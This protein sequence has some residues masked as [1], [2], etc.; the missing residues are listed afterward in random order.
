MDDHGKDRQ[1]RRMS[2][3]HHSPRNITR[4]NHASSGPVS[5]PSFSPIQRKRRRPE[6]DIFQ[7]E[8]RKI[9]PPTFSG[10]HMKGEDE[11]AWLLEMKKYFSCMTTHP[12]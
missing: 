6:V 9:K 4:I 7:G 3:I 2:M 1:S 5:S 12:R 10:K 8:L 11:K